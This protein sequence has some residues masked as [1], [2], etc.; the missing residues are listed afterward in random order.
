M[1]VGITDITRAMVMSGR[2]DSRVCQ[3]SK[4]EHLL[5]VL[6]MCSAIQF[7]RDWS[8]TP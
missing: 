5:T 8:S 6:A 4:T 7:A 2:A 3:F 1:F